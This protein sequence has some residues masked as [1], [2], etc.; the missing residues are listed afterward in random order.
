MSTM[1]MSSRP[2]AAT[3]LRSPKTRLPV[4]ST[5]T[6]SPSTELPRASAWTRTPSSAQLPMSAQSNAAG[7]STSR[8]VF[9][10]TLRSTTSTGSRR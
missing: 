2:I 4:V 10:I 7:T 5:S 8:S 6:A 9:S 1:I 3:S